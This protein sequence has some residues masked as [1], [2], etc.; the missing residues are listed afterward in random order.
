VWHSSEIKKVLK[1]KKWITNV[2]ENPAVLQIR[3]LEDKATTLFK[4]LYC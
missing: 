2:T 4:G 1:P 3:L